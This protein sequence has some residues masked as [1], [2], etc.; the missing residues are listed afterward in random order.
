MHRGRLGQ[1]PAVLRALIAA[2]PVAALLVHGKVGAAEIDGGGLRDPEVL[3]LSNLIELIEE[4]R[5]SSL[6]PAERWAEMEIETADGRVLSSGPAV[7]RGS[8][9]NPLSDAEISA[10]FRGLMVDSGFGERADAVEDFVAT[11]EHR[12]SVGPL[13]DLI[14]QPAAP[15]ALRGAAE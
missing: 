14:F 7:A 6:F 8:A 3:R 9:E 5:Y 10:K 4:P 12:A 13:F 1:F 11:L 2:V 15:A